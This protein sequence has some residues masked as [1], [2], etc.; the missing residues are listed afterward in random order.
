MET[1][2]TDVNSREHKIVHE[3][4]EIAGVF[5]ETL[6]K[7]EDQL[8]S[9]KEDMVKE[10]DQTLEKEEDIESKLSP[11]EEEKVRNKLQNI[12]GGT[13]PHLKA[14]ISITLPKDKY[15][16]IYDKLMSML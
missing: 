8:E 15:K 10:I 1:A 9:E 13:I 4:Q 14:I 6:Q 5:I 2:E 16:V 3:E 12:T 11:E 7:G